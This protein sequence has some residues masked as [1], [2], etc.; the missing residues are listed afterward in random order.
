MLL[1]LGYAGMRGIFMWGREVA[2]RDAMWRERFDQRDVMWRERE[3]EWTRQLK[4]CNE[5]ETMWRSLA[6]QGATAA[7]KALTVAAD[8]TNSRKP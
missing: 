7:D 2:A 4:E 1:M 6:L 3:A 5:R 8:V